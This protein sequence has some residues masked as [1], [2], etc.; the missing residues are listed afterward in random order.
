MSMQSDSSVRAVD[1][2][3]AGLLQQADRDEEALEHLHH[4]LRQQ[5]KR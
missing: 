4:D 2:V 5:R 3:L 1:A